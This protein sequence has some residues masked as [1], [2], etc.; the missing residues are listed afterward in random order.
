MLG[1]TVHVNK[2]LSHPHSHSDIFAF[3][4]LLVFNIFT[5]DIL[6]STKVRF[7]EKLALAW[8]RL[9]V[10]GADERLDVQVSGFL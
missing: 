6:L 3:T 1:I 7:T 2:N 9:A 5:F 8:Q 10:S 4:L